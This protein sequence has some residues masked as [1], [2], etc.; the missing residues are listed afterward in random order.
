MTRLERRCRM[1]LRAYPTLY[2]QTRG[3]EIIG[4]L[5]EATPEGRAWPLARD[6]RSLVMGGLQ[7][8]AA[9]N[10]QLT[11]AANLRI[12]AL[13]G[14]T[15]Y[16]AF[17]AVGDL[18]FVVLELT[19][20]TGHAHVNPWPPLLVWALVGV[21]VAAA[22]VSRRKMLVLIAATAASAALVLATTWQQGS[23]VF[24]V[25][26]LACLASLAL[27]ARSAERP[28]RRW[29]WPVALIAG[30]PLA[31]ILVPGIW[32]L[33]TLVVVLPALSLLWVVIDAR[34][35]VAAAVFVLA[36]WLPV[37]IASVTAGPNIAAAI[38]ILTVSA[39]AG[40]AV[41]LLH[42]QSARVTAGPQS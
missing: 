14:V 19:R 25:P 24:S 5:Q 10:R 39:V 2:R 27:L 26:E 8:R 34:P 7:A 35:A 23:V 9:L 1:L 30:W 18:S 3:E 11:T 41:W 17:I 37:G 28:G 36:L 4:T 32:A 38:P 40:V 42:R 31:Q 20:R 22:W 33:S 6:V 12:A 21:A 15:T 29:L 16:L 13:I